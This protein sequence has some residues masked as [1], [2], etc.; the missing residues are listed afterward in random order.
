MVNSRKTDCHFSFSPV[1]LQV[2][3]QKLRVSPQRTHLQQ[4][5][6][7]HSASS[8]VFQDPLIFS[9]IC[10]LS[11]LSRE[12][13]SPLWMLDVVLCHC[14][15]SRVIWGC[16]H[17]LPSLKL[18]LIC[19]H[20]CFHWWILEKKAWLYSLFTGAT[21][22]KW[23]EVQ[24]GLGGVQWWNCSQLSCPYC[25]IHMSPCGSYMVLLKLERSYSQHEYSV[26]NDLFWVT[27]WYFRI[28][29]MLIICE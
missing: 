8:Q 12:M 26:Y 18:E 22:K 5:L 2:G 16:H 15:P 1:F 17:L 9:D 20:F 4:C 28:Q 23:S 27:R 19:H 7:S 21:L 6:P 14:R 11:W 3:I 13:Q 29:Q 25:L 24:L 10:L